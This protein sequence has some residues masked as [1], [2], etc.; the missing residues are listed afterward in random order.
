MNSDTIP[1]LWR[2]TVSG[3][4]D[5]KQMINVHKTEAKQRDEAW[6]RH[7]WRCGMQNLKGVGAQEKL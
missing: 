4:E 2:L 1:A 3:T 5:L 7:L 6:V